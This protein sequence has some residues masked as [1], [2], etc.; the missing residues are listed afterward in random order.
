MRVY[1]QR[2]IFFLALTLSMLPMASGASVL[3]D[4]EE[5]IF[6]LIAPGAE[7]VFLVGDF[8][9][10][11][12]TVDRMVQRDN[13]FEIR[14]FLVTGKYRYMFIVDGEPVN[15]PD[16]PA[17]GDDGRAFFI[18]RET[19]D[20][21]EIVYSNLQGNKP[22][23]VQDFIQ[24]S[25]EGYLRVGEDSKSAYFSFPLRHK[26]DMGLHAE[27]VPGFEFDIEHPDRL[28]SFFLRG[29]GSYRSDR[30][31]IRA[32]NRSSSLDYGDPLSLFGKT[33]PFLYPAGLFFRGV[34]IEGEGPFGFDGKIVYAGRIEGYDPVEMDGSFSP[35]ATEIYELP[36][37]QRS[38]VDSDILS[39]R[40]G[41]RSGEFSYDYLYRHDIGPGNRL[42]MSPDEESLFRGFEKMSVHGFWLRYDMKCNLDI[43]VQYL[44]GVTSL[45][46][47]QRS[48]PEGE[49]TRAY[50]YSQDWEKGDR[51]CF[52]LHYR[53]EKFAVLISSSSTIIDGDS[54]LR[55]E[56]SS[57]IR[58]TYKAEVELNTEL[59]DLSIRGLADIFP[60]NSAAE[61][62]W[63]QK[64]NFWLDGDEIS[65]RRLPFLYSKGI[66]EVGLTLAQSGSDSIT[67]PYNT[68][69]QISVN[70]CGDITRSG[71]RVTEF[72]LKK[73]FFLDNMF[74]VHFDARLVLYDD[75]RSVGEKSFMDI[76]GGVC[77]RTGKS[78][79]IA[80]GS[81]ISP[82]YF[83]RWSN[84]FLP[85]GRERFIAD[86]GVF[87][88][89]RHTTEAGL[90]E[91][92]YKAE[93]SISD[94]WNIT[95]EAGISF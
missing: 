24:Y 35:P 9:E 56:R 26:G 37:D 23:A 2:T 19:K 88:I 7:R 67:V 33:G 15:D 55:G 30:G 10:W 6:R 36:F 95:I 93:Q 85:F 77:W 16:S 3:L 1:C 58:S 42:W 84:S 29:T 12:P 76:W 69:G 14:L 18:F 83:D 17:Y 31:V 21:Y 59:F 38:P 41:S 86:R 57:D 79:W 34:E 53:Q 13:G 64:W 89:D 45:V 68:T 32:F 94:E 73:G 92:L 70:L 60:D 74:S 25:G 22:L 80:L 87:Q 91:D 78:G 40:I 5:L 75:D 48:D 28:R 50:E 61:Y 52:A 8:N 43:E 82:S 54:L 20:R 81:G 90:L 44:T 49:D 11:N 27:L 65:L 72:L 4:E 71:L 66:Y 47:S 63:S 62:F 39:I 46:S 51:A